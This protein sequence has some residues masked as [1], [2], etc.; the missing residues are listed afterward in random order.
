MGY[1][2]EGASLLFRLVVLSLT[3][4]PTQTRDKSS[5]P[6][7]TADTLHIEAR[8]HLEPV[9]AK[10]RGLQVTSD[11][12]SRGEKDVSVGEQVERLIRE[13]KSSKNLGLMYAGW[14]AFLFA[15]PPVPA[16][17]LAS[18]SLSQVCLVLNAIRA[19][20][21]SLRSRT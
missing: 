9:G 6:Q 11:K 1:E 19:G 20:F 12:D 13:A 10:L 8:K 21:V 16:A 5:M 4:L 18:L 7:V 15:T 17:D 14:Y 2:K 3:S